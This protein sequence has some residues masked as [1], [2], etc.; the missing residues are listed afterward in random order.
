MRIFFKDPQMSLLSPLI[1][2]HYFI[3]IADWLSP[4]LLYFLISF[5]SSLLLKYKERNKNPSKSGTINTLVRCS[6]PIKPKIIQHRAIMEFFVIASD[7]IAC[8]PRV[9]STCA[10]EFGAL[11]SLGMGQ[12]VLASGRREM[13]PVSRWNRC[14]QFFGCSSRRES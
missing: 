12:M 11:E 6:D 5:L 10:R 9:L 4:S 1:L 8:L 13:F 3:P 14:V 2:H 7:K